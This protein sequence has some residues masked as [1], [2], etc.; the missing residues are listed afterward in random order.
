MCYMQ[1]DFEHALSGATIADIGKAVYASA[2]DTLT[3]TSTDN[4]F[5][6]HVDDVPSAGTII[7]RIEPFATAP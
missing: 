4:T 1:G 5:V 6:G 7:L 2:D 3:L